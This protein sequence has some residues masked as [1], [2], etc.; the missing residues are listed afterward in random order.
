MIQFNAM[1]VKCN[2]VGGY[3][4][5][6]ALKHKTTITDIVNEVRHHLGLEAI[7]QKLVENNPNDDFHQGHRF[8][9][10]DSNVSRLVTG[11]ANYCYS[12]LKSEELVEMHL[13]AVL[14]N[15]TFEEKV[16]LVVD[17]CRDCAGADHWYTF[18]KQWD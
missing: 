11:L 6:A 8:L 3:A 16:I 14:N 4:Y 2:G 1:E 13:G 18:E 5:Q 15:L 7:W 9:E 12:Y 10:V 17:A